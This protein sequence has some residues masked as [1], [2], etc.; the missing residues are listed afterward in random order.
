[1]EVAYATALWRV[2]E[3]GMPGKKAVQ[4]LQDA[5]KARGREALMPRIAKAFARIAARD[6]E[7]NGVTI[8]I[9]H[10]KEQRK[11]LRDA[12]Q[13]LSKLR[14]EAGEVSVKTDETLIGG[15]RLEGRELLVDSSFKKNLIDMYNAATLRT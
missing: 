4:S 6:T 14:I 3:G 2:I 8:S 5:L 15:W 13:F 12:K 11:A 1:M 7:R 10:E 9:A